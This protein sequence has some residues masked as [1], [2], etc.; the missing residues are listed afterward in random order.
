MINIWRKYDNFEF[1][2]KSP[3]W[4]ALSQIHIE[5]S[6]NLEMPKALFDDVQKVADSTV[7]GQYD[8]KTIADYRVHWVLA[9]TLLVA[10]RLMQFYSYVK[11]RFSNCEMIMRQLRTTQNKAY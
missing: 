3:S 1:L 4:Q 10:E 2:R 11:Q 6:H 9:K 7:P 5:I 8:E